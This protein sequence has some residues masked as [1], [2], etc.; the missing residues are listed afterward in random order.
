MATP[1]TNVDTAQIQA[2]VSQWEQA[3]SGLQ[4]NYTAMLN[5]QENLAAN[6]TGETFST[7]GRALEAWLSDCQS[8]MSALHQ[9]VTALGGNINVYGNADAGGLE[10][11]N[12]VAKNNNSNPGIF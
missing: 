8:V 6:A 2:L 1:G 11:A 12:S 10:A 7:F 9:I 3:Y 5:E 4:G